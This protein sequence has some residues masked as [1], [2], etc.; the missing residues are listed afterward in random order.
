MITQG[1]DGLS[2]GVWANGFNTD[3]KSFA[4]EVFLPTLPSLPLT[5]WALSHIDIQ[6]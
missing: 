1:T 4:V 6:K 3:L 2:R 5:E